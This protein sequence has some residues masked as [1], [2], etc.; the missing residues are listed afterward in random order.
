MRQGQTI[1]Y[2]IL[3]VKFTQHGF[4]HSRRP[5]DVVMMQSGTH[6][7]SMEMSVDYDQYMD[8]RPSAT[9]GYHRN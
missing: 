7:F 8:L 2:H 3:K 4:V 9:N 6:L 1:V 5:K